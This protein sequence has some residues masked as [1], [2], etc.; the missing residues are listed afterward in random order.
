MYQSTRR[1]THRPLRDGSAVDR[2]HVPA[3]L[4]LEIAGYAWD[5]ALR[6]VSVGEMSAA[7]V[8]IVNVDANFSREL[9]V[10]DA[11]FFVS[12]RTI[13]RTSFVLETS[14]EQG[15]GV[16][17]IAAFTV[18]QIVDGVAAPL[19]SRRAEFLRRLGA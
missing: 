2:A 10:G 13:G 1:L 4:A 8:V 18:V 15:G 11:Q 7:D 9:L 16:A 19:S 5:D 17:A 3:F 14:I 12:L 6:E